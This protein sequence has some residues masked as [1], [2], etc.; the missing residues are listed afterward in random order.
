MMTRYRCR[1]ALCM[2][3]SL[4]LHMDV[5]PAKE[6]TFSATRLKTCWLRSSNTCLSVQ[7]GPHE[8]MPCKS[9]QVSISKRMRRF[10][11]RSSAPERQDLFLP[12]VNQTPMP[13][14]RS[15]ADPKTWSW[16][17][18]VSST[19]TLTISL[20]SGPRCW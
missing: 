16:S 14:R 10:L 2:L 12:F 1:S 20:I 8:V 17:P 18:T 9:M 4:Y 3:I 13:V 5:F 7:T 15:K 19:D 11:E 6:W